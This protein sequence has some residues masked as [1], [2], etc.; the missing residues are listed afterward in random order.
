ML[1]FINK[2]KTTNFFL[3][4]QCTSRFTDVVINV[5]TFN[6]SVKRNAMHILEIIKIV[7]AFNNYGA[8]IR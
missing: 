6:S 7:D 1:N 8:I 2:D 3:I 4:D 5:L